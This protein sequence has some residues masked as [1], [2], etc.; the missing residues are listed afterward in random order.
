MELKSRK[1]RISVEEVSLKRLLEPIVRPTVVLDEGAIQEVVA[2][3][4]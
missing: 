3:I 4:A 1:G 2:L